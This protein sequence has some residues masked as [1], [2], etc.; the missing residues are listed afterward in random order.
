MPAWKDIGDV[1]KLARSTLCCS[2]LIRLLD[3]P[4]SD[5]VKVRRGVQAIMK[6]CAANAVVLPKYVMDRAQ[7]AMTLSL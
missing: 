5:K 2:M 6:E 4:G 3:K 7:L 1:E